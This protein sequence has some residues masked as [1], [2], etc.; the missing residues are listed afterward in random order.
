MTENTQNITLL[1]AEDEEDDYQLVKE[2]LEEADFTGSLRRVKDGKE[3][4]DFL[5]KRNS[6]ETPPD[7]EKLLLLLDINMPRKNGRE[8]LKEIKAHPALRKIPVVVLTASGGEDDIS[9]FYELGASSYIKKPANY[10]QLAD[11]IK[12]FKK[13]WLEN[14]ELPCIKPARNLS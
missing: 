1:I 6:R 10:E 4:M 12:T 13:Y 14:V 7:S 3:L 2:A 5:L 11:F 9:L 8:A